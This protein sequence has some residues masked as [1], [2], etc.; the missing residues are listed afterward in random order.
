MLNKT[1]LKNIAFVTIGTLM[2]ALAVNW[3]IIPNHFGEGGVT[4]LTLLFHYVFHFDPA[5]TNLALNSI[6]LMIGWK[7][8]ERKTLYYTF[9]SL[10]EMTVFLKYLQLPGFVPENIFV[11]AIVAGMLSGAGLGLV[12]LGNGTT[13]GSD[14]I[15]MMMKKYLGMN[16]S[17]SLL[18]ID[19]L[20]V[21]PLMFVIG[22]EKGVVTLVML[23]ILSK[24]MNFIL[25]GFNP[26]K[27]VMVI[28]NHH[29]AIARAITEQLDRGVTILKGYGYYSKAEKDV[30]YVVVNRL[31]LLPIQRIIHEA[32]PNAFV[33]ISD[34]HQVIGEGFTFYLDKQT[35]E[36]RAS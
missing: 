4:G 33:T 10:A 21:T 29:D 13:A 17:V 35:G 8:L 16:V 3:V 27:S 1:E 26:R 5:L 28:T 19:V 6:L 12:V 18:L 22:L 32:D 36:R 23:F 24:V 31:Q 25:E 34:V 7:Y 14:I 30:L 9:L 15:A 11:A 2:F 20:I